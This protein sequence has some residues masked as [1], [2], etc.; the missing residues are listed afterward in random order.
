[1]PISA[2]E[3]N[4]AAEL[5]Y[6][7]AG[8]WLAERRDVRILILNALPATGLHALAEAQALSVQQAFR[9][10]WLQLQ[11]LGLTPAAT[12]GEIAAGEAGFE[13]ALVLPGKQREENLGLL[14]TGMLS[15]RPEGMLMA[16]CANDMGG[17]SYEKR[18]AELAGATDSASKS[19][20]RLFRAQRTEAFDAGLAEAWIRE[21][22]PRPVPA[23]GLIARPGNFSWERPDAGSELLRRYLENRPPAGSGM[24]LCCGYGYLA[25]RLLAACPGISELYL[26]D[27]DRHALDCAIANTEA[28]HVAVHARW[29]D[30]TGESLPAGLD[31]I[32][33]N[34][35]FHR[36]K[37]QDIALGQT[38]ARRACQ[39]LKP[40]GRLILVANRQLPYEQACREL[41][42]TCDVAEQSEGFKIL[43]G[44]R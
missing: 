11:R 8:Q 20:C 26:V 17:R 16:A 43:E 6:T 33:L 3:L 19:H 21:A 41:L 42:T 7:K 12:I 18:L 24:D 38:I 13:L 30:A 2:S 22:A 23:H 35:P 1:A 36:G 40:G 29:L 14:A 28:A 39:S 9:P 15:L 4:S 31:W 34:P 32:V 25:Q 27:A 44:I 37:A 10:D 5:L